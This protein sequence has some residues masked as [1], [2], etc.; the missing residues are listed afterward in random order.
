MTNGQRDPKLQQQSSQYQQQQHQQRFY[1]FPT[2]R[3]L[4]LSL[5]FRV[6]NRHNNNNKINTSSTFGTNSTM[7]TGNNN[8][9]SN[10]IY[11]SP[12][13]ALVGACQTL[14]VRTKIGAVSWHKSKVATISRSNGGPLATI[15]ESRSGKTRDKSLRKHFRSSI[16]SNGGKET[17]NGNAFVIQCNGKDNWCL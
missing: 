17:N 5:S 1:M 15:R 12:Q 9:N 4:S 6:K 3:A 7:P 8:S 10:H 11:E 16:Q 14:P 2:P 13:D